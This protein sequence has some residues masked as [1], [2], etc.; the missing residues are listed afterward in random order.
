MSKFTMTTLI[1]V[2]VMLTMASLAFIATQGAEQPRTPTQA[3][4]NPTG[5]ME[6]APH[7]LPIERYDAH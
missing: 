3:T 7:N 1:V 5:M 6:H 2:A 4:V